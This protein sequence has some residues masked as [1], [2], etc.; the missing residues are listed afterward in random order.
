MS[1]AYIMHIPA[2]DGEAPEGW[3]EH[4]IGTGMSGCASSAIRVKLLLLS[5]RLLTRKSPL[6]WCGPHDIRE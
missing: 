1:A 3:H 4:R 2:G 6:Y 5:S